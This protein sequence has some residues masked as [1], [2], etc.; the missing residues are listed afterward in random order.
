MK[1]TVRLGRITEGRKRPLLVKLENESNKMDSLRSA[2]LLKKYQK[3]MGKEGSNYQ[4]SNR[5]RK[6]T[7]QKSTRDVE[8]KEKQRTRMVCKGW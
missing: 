7:N 3:G 5:E 2:K 1:E 6:R 4:G 8:G